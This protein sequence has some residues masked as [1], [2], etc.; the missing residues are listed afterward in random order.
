[1]KNFK[2]NN[3]FQALGLMIILASLNSCNHYYYA[4]NAH[5]VPLFQEKNEARIT[6]A[7][8]GGDEFVGTEFQSAYSITKNIGVMFNGFFVLPG[9]DGGLGSN[10]MGEFFNPIYSSNTTNAAWGKGHLFEFGV[11]Y[12]KALNKYFVF[13]TYGGFGWGKATNQYDRSSTSTVN[14]R[15]HFIQPSIGFTTEWFDIAFSTRFCGLQ[16]NNIDYNIKID[17]YD[18]VDLEYIENNRFS[19]LFEPAITLRGGWRY[20]KIQTQWG[21]SRNLNN[22]KLAQEIL[23]GNIGIYVVITDKYKKK[24]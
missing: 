20:I 17:S 23:N 11:G 8:S 7:R 15:R 24:A 21:L 5:N 14:F 3:I 4:P 2:I 6:I 18:K 22:P 13:E 16:Y 19:V 1:M 10:E 12:F 9:N